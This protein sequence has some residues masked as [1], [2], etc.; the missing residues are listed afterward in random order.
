MS[1]QVNNTNKTSNNTTNNDLTTTNLR[2]GSKFDIYDDFSQRE[3]L[4]NKQNVKTGGTSTTSD[5][6]DTDAMINNLYMLNNSIRANIGLSLAIY[7]KINNF[8]HNYIHNYA[9]QK[10]K[11]SK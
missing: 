10:S 1:K 4:E 2:I 3:T 8:D 9:N 11:N 6:L 5:N 7:K